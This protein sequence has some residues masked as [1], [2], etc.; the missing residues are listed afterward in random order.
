[1]YTDEHGRPPAHQPHRT[2][3]VE[4]MESRYHKKT[5]NLRVLLGLHF[6][7]D[8]GKNYRIIR[9]HFSNPS[10]TSWPKKENWTKKRALF[11]Y[12]FK[13]WWILICWL[14]SS[15]SCLARSRLLKFCF[16]KEVHKTSCS[17]E[18]YFNLCYNHQYNKFTYF[19]LEK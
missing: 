7:G 6:D 4:V 9:F 15:F 2:S 11:Y 8:R 12:F 19:Y 10:P 3:A 14:K 16:I 5:R 18:I 17:I 1:M 13:I